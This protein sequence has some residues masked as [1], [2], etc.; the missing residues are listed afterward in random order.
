MAPLNQT[1]SFTLTMAS[2]GIEL[3]VCVRLPES[4]EPAFAALTEASN[5]AHSDTCCEAFA[6]SAPAL[7]PQVI[8]MHQQFLRDA[9]AALARKAVRDRRS[10]ASSFAVNPK[11]APA[12][13]AAP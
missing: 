8:A 10:S 11:D 12:P 9:F 7:V 13:E 4:P 3:S 6:Q 2:E 5:A 1:S